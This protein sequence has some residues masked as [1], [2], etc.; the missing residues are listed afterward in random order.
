[1]HDGA[2]PVAAPPPPPPVAVVVPDRVE[3]LARVVPDP[4]ASRPVVADQPGRLDPADG[5]FPSAGTRVKAGTVLAWLTP[6]LSAPARRDLDAELATAQRDARFGR[7]QVQ[8]FNVDEAEA[9][10]DDLSRPLP[11]IQILSD[12]RSAQARET[13]L[14]RGLRERVPLVA[15]AAAT[16]LASRAQAGRVVAAGDVLFE[17]ATERGLAIELRGAERIADPLA[18]AAL[19]DGRS[20]AL[21]LLSDR[22]DPDARTR[23]LLFAPTGATTLVPGAP[24]RLIATRTASPVAMP[25]STAS[26]ARRVTVTKPAQRLLGIR[27]QRTRD[28][29]TRTRTTGE[30]VS[31]PDHAAIVQAPEAGRLEE[32]SAGWPLA[33]RTV[34]RDQLLAILHP[35]MSAAER[36]RRKASLAQVEQKLAVARINLERLR[37]QTQGGGAPA[38]GNVYLDQAALEV[39]TLTRLRA[40]AVEGLEG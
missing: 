34:A 24:V 37:V 11:S 4:R 38:G 30:I 20:V 33:G 16:I 19:V 2:A 25:V 15:P 28:V 39:E 27:T 12:Y 26:D 5:G 9:A 6:A 18:L 14:A 29:P 35:Q 1:M 13:D 7:I 31:P 23:V 36:A 3:W 8:R 40:L 22:F 32:P 17:L 21:E 10:A